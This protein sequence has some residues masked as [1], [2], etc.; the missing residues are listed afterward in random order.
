VSELV[1]EKNRGVLVVYVN[2]PRILDDKT[3]KDLGDGLLALMQ[4]ATDSKLLV[5]FQGV[6]FMGSSMIGRIV[7]LH[8]KCKQNKVEMKL[9]DISKDILEVFRITQLDKILEIHDNQEQAL[10]SFE[11][12]GWFG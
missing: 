1:S 8:K 10:K 2:T 3:V 6:R 7:Q 12:S 4:K 9:S 11:R 5:S